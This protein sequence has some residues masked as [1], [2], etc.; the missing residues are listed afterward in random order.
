[1]LPKAGCILWN[2]LLYLR[3]AAHPIPRQPRIHKDV[4]RDRIRHAFTNSRKEQARTAMS[5]QNQR[6]VRGNGR[7]LPGNCLGMLPPVGGRCIAV[8]CEPGHE[9]RPAPLLEA[10][11]HGQPG[12]G[13]DQRTMDENE[14]GIHRAYGL[15][16]ADNELRADDI[17]GEH[18]ASEQSAHELDG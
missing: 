6:A 2:A 14:H 12:A 17:S 8:I 13:A 7:Q 15:D 18:E 9:D 3:Q 4:S 1:M 16:I 10:V 5:H 11:G